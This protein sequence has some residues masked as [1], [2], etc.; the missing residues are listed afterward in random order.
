VVQ[1][2]APLA[3]GLGAYLAMILLVDPQLPR[4]ALGQARRM[5]GRAA[6]APS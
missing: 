1:L 2:F 3:V 6:L 4:H 5:V